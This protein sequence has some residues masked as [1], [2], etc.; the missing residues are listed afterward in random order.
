MLC[1]DKFAPEEETTVK[2]QSID[3]YNNKLKNGITKKINFFKIA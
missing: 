1:V 3:S 2:E